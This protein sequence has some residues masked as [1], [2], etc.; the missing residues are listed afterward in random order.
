MASRSGAISLLA[1]LVLVGCA[2]HEARV[3]SA[4]DALDSGRTE[5]AIAALDRELGGPSS[6]LSPK[7]EGDAALLVLDRATLLQADQRFEDSQRDFGVADKAI[8]VLDLSRGAASELGR[9]LFSDA[10]GPYRAPPFEKLLLNSFNMANYLARGDLS[11]A[12]VEA[13]RLA[14]TQ[15]FLAT[16]AEPTA[17]LGFGSWLAGFAFERSGR[18]AEAIRHYD[19]ALRVRRYET[20]VEPLRT[21]VTRNP[22]TPAIDALLGPRVTVAPPSLEAGAAVSEPGPPSVESRPSSIEARASTDGEGELVIVVGYGRV[23][24]KVPVRLPIGLAVSLVANDLS[25]FDRERAARIAAKGLVTWVNFPRLAEAPVL[26]EEPRVLLDG[27]AVRLELAVDVEREVRREWQRHEGTVILAAVTRTLAR[28]A[29]SSAIEAGTNAA[30]KS[31]G[32]ALGLF[33]GLLASAALTA[34]DTPDTRSWAT[35]PARVSLA[36]VRVPAGKHTVVIR[37]RGQERSHVV[38]MTPGGWSFVTTHALR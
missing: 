9:Y 34:A 21:L 20:L 15:G 5:A 23:P 12:R 38:A 26:A 24:P 36:R 31:R 22:S 27:R 18:E 2:G 13:R 8:E 17:L 25:P 19:D 35:L 30:S 29:A 11:G 1:A 37:A 6:E 16:S 10:A 33:A 4:L 7:L 28:F 3:G 14:V 32:G